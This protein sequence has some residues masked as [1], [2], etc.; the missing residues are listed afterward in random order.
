MM[1]DGLES[2]APV[3]ITIFED[4]DRRLSL[5]ADAE[6]FDGSVPDRLPL[7]QSSYRPQCY[8]FNCH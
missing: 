4:V 3:T 5:L 7:S 6:P 2:L 8:W 1:S